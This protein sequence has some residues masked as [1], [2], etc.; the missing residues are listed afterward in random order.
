MQFRNRQNRF[1]RWMFTGMIFVAGGNTT[2]LLVRLSTSSGWTDAVDAMQG[3]CVGI[4][5][6]CFFVGLRR[7]QRSC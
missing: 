2:H 5:L 6:A 1:N 7:Q 4:A 3:A